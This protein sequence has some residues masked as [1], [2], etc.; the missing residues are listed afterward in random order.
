MANPVGARP[1]FSA[2]AIRAPARNPE[3]VKH[4]ELTSK[5]QSLYPSG[6]GHTV[7]KVGDRLMV[8]DKK[9]R[10]VGDLGDSPKHAES[11]LIGAR[12]GNSAARER[13]GLSR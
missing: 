7:Q 9:N 10:T 5:I 2:A 4:E 8:M 12:S 11:I 13:L 6:S 1:G 3:R